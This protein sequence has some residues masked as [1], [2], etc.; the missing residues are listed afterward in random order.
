MIGAA[1]SSDSCRG[2]KAGFTSSTGR[3]QVSCQQLQNQEIVQEEVQQLAG[4]KGSKIKRQ[5][6]TTKLEHYGCEA[7]SVRSN[8]LKGRPTKGT[9]EVIRSRCLCGGK[10]QQ[11]EEVGL[12]FRPDMGGVAQSK[13]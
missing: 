9:D 1:D 12:F 8:V 13:Q 3:I 11:L 7:Q 10:G 5:C 2:M 4:I 6:K